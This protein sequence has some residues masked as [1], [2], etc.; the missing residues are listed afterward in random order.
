MCQV[1]QTTITI[2]Q[3]GPIRLLGTFSVLIDRNYDMTEPVSDH[4]LG[5]ENGK[6]TF[7]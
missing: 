3:V 6:K 5:V 2:T 1:A 7:Y 4:L